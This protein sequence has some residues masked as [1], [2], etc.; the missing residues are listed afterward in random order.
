[1]VEVMSQ[2]SR[3][4]TK[5]RP[6]QRGSAGIARLDEDLAFI[7]S[8]PTATNPSFLRTLPKDAARLNRGS[9]TIGLAFALLAIASAAVIHER[10]DVTD[11]EVPSS[12]RPA[13]SSLRMASQLPLRAAGRIEAD[14]RKMVGERLDPVTVP[15]RSQSRIAETGGALR[16]REITAHSRASAYVDNSLEYA[17]PDTAGVRIAAQSGTVVTHIAAAPTTVTPAKT[18]SVNIAAS[19]DIPALQPTDPVEDSLPTSSQDHERTAAHRRA[20]MDSILNLR[21]QW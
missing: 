17:R 18:L 20:A 5:G 12:S 19:N 21:R 9:V 2:G 14:D 10:L 7:L 13:P 4:I 15:S 1:M 11:R 6:V 3:H 16:P 8:T